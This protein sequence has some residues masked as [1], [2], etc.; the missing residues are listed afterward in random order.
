MTPRRY[1][2]TAPQGLTV[3]NRD[4]GELAESQQDEIRALRQA[5]QRDLLLLA[6]VLTHC[7]FDS[8]A[9]LEELR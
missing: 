4:H 5:R 3:D 1:L 6:V 9:E 7:S 2:S 8:Q